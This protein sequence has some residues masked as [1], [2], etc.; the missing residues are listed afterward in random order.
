MLSDYDLPMRRSLPV[1]T[2]ETRQD[3]D[4]DGRMEIYWAHWHRYVTDE[5]GKS[6]PDGKYI[7]IPVEG[8]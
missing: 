5:T 3:F 4:G 7:L 1:V 8:E 2:V 6:V